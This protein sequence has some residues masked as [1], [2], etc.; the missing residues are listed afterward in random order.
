MT[1]SICAWRWAATYSCRFERRQTWPQRSATPSAQRDPA[2]L[3]L[4]FG[5]E[6]GGLSREELRLSHARLTVP[7]NPAYPVLNLAQ[8]VAIVLAGLSEGSFASVPPA[9]AM[10]QAAPLAELDGAICHLQNVM[11]ESGFLDQANPTRVTDQLRRWLGRTVP[12]RR[13]IA[14]LHA[15]AAHVKYLIERP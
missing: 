13:E 7:T 4:V 14:I 1:R 12:T 11:L 2:V 8:A 9:D 10:D 5:P 3:A 6:R 15:L